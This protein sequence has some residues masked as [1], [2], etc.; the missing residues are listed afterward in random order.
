[1]TAKRKC[2]KCGAEQ[3]SSTMQGLCPDCVIKVTLGPLTEDAPAPHSGSRLRYFGDYE[4]LEE[5]A[6]GGMG[7]VWRA[8]Q[9]SLNRL[10]AVKMIRAG[11]LAGDTEVRRFHAEAEASASLDHPN[12][13]PLYEVGE[14][15]GQQY[16]SMKLI[17]GLSLA[18]GMQ[19]G[20][21][22]KA[23]CPDH[24][25]GAA[26]VPGR[27]RCCASA[28]RLLAKVSR[29]VHHAHQRGILHRD[30]KPG[31]IL[32]DAQGEPH[33]TDFGLAKVLTEANPLATLNPQLTLSGA[34]LGTPSY[35]A[36]EQA[37]GKTHTLTT[38]ADIYSLGAILY[39]M[40]A[41]QPPFKAATPLETLR[42]VTEQEPA[43]PKSLNAFVDPD[44]ETICLKCLEKDPQHR[45]GSAQGL[46]EDLD[47][48]LRYEP[49][50]ARR[51]TALERVMKWTQRHPARAAT[52]AAFH[53]VL[54]L[55]AGGVLWEWREANYHRG[56]A[57][58]ALRQSQTH[59][60]PC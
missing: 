27:L 32:V 31:N 38:A 45:Y 51:S 17:T 1:M 21:R 34:V 26:F 55:G 12:I 49:I 20:C 10:V 37:A 39:E 5:I 53:L 41:G 56:I 15:A 18:A 47:R 30:L 33:V 23:H 48:W 3:S 36:P 60:P 44:L 7:V 35:M 43:R 58:A 25:S 13:V 19:A 11:L 2:P 4:L 40:L 52:V 6:C 22:S 29:A 16:F 59:L 24:R 9:I 8:R 57:E 14:H 46:A 50:L 42:L 28:V 54:L